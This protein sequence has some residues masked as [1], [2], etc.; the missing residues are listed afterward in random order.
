[1]YDVYKHISILSVCQSDLEV[2]NTGHTTIRLESWSELHVLKSP[3][4]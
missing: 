1:M 3:V 2:E 4:Q